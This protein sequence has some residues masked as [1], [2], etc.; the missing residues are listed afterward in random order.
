[1]RTSLFA[2][3]AG[4]AL[5]TTVGCSPDQKSDT[6]TTTTTT[7]ADT[8]VVTTTTA[9]ADTTAFHPYA[10]SLSRR[11]ATDLALTDT[12]LTRKLRRVYHIRAHRLAQ[13]RVQY[14]RD[15]S[16]YY[17]ALR[18]LNDDADR[19][20]QSLLND[21]ARY[22]VYEQN[23]AAYY[24]GT[25]YTMTGGAADPGASSPV[26]E[27]KAEKD[28]DVKIK[29]ADGAKVKVGDDGD[30]KIKHADGT[31]TKTGDDGHKAKK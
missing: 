16:G 14:V 8:T 10:D 7:A 3:L 6:T 1:M 4:A 24:Q 29:Y 19:A 11:V 17:R 22:K 13:A 30:V 28:G 12:A 27:M 20:L 15:T 9:E 2:L 18:T 26:K 31:K 25:P 23:R 5:L 21:P